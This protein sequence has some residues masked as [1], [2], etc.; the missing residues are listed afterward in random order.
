[1]CGW[2]GE[3]GCS[4]SPFPRAPVQNSSRRPRNPLGR[5]HTTRSRMA[6]SLPSIPVT[7]A[8]LRGWCGRPPLT[9][10]SRR[11][12]HGH[13]GP[14]GSMRTRHAH[15]PCA[16]IRV[17]PRIRLCGFTARASRSSLRA[18]SEQSRALAADRWRATNARAAARAG[19][20]GEHTSSLWRAQWAFL[21]TRSSAGTRNLRTVEDCQKP[22]T[23]IVRA[24]PSPR[25]LPRQ[26][27][28]CAVRTA[29]VRA[30]H[31]CTELGSSIR[32]RVY[33][34]SDALRCFA[35]R[36]LRLLGQ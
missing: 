5:Y 4:V 19:A 9:T 2:G 33:C 21:L 18:A 11:S 12:H 15:T 25:F 27:Q 29:G 6:R 7:S 32:L 10:C 24:S 26:R 34:G 3:C 36:K 13:I 35:D 8:P 23:L 16:H 30:W 17:S 14:S 1:M 31:V 28:G 20:R 22:G